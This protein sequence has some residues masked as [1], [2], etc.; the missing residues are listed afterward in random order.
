M[1]RLIH[2]SHYQQTIL[3]LIWLMFIIFGFVQLPENV[4]SLACNTMLNIANIPTLGNTATCADGK[5]VW[6][7]TW[8]RFRSRWRKK[9][10]KKIT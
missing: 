7:L 2:F 5:F 3:S 4:H 8:E 1:A 9:S 10:N 6:N